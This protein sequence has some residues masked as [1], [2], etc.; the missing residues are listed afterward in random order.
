MSRNVT[1]LERGAFGSSRMERR[2][3]GLRIDVLAAA[4]IV[5]LVAGAD[6]RAA[7]PC[8]ARS[9]DKPRKDP[10]ASLTLPR[11]GGWIMLADGVTL[12]V[13]IPEKA[14][15]AY[16]DTLADK[17]IKR[18]DLPF[19]P[20][21][22]AGQGKYLFASV[23]GA[24]AIHVLE[25][26][27][28]VDRKEIHLPA[29]PVTGLACHRERGPLFASIPDP[30]LAGAIVAVDPNSGTIAYAGV[31]LPNHTDPKKVGGLTLAADPTNAEGLYS[32]VPLAAGRHA[33]PGLG[34]WRVVIQSIVPYR[35][36]SGPPYKPPH[37]DPQAMPAGM[38]A[39]VGDYRHS[40]RIA[41]TSSMVHASPDGKRVGIIDIDEKGVA[42][43]SAQNFNERF[44]MMDCPSVSDFA[45]HP[46]LDLAVAEGE[47]SGRKKERALYLFNG[48]SLA[49][50]TQFPLGHGSSDDADKNGRL[51][52]FA[53]RGTKLVYFDGSHGKRLRFFPLAL[54]EKDQA[55]LEKAYNPPHKR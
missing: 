12:I 54:T 51:L 11:I 31:M 6:A 25:V 40:E 36:Y 1:L 30:T 35:P 37:H 33:T 15:L 39:V 44:G 3:I 4:L 22:L 28:G 10:E 52:T 26:G 13:A 8:D 42:V 5:G 41:K 23:S 53:G 45:F 24:S 29:G 2:S 20:D 50:V 47:G 14:Q 49:E 9:D 46:V 48:K 18:I 43:L 17:E 19:K 27:S 32:L 7:E 34:V 16:I 55:V 21:L 38:V